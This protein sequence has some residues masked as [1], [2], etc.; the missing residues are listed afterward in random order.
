MLFNRWRLLI[1]GA[2]FGSVITAGIFI[3]PPIVASKSWPWRWAD[4]TG[5]GEDTIK[6]TSTEKKGGKNSSIEKVI[7]TDETRS[8]KTLWDFLEL[9]AVPFLLLY[10]GNQLQQKDK[11]VA[12]I[13]LR[14]EALLNY[15]D[16]VSDLLIN[17]KVNSLQPN[18]TLLEL[19]NDIIRTR[20]L[21]ILRSFGKDG[22]RKGS[23]IRFLIDAEFISNWHSIVLDLSSASLKG[24]K[25]SGTKLSR[26]K[27][28]KAD[29]SDADLSDA[30][31]SHADIRNANLIN[32]DLINA[33]LTGADLTGADLTGA[34]LTGADLT[35][36][37]LRD[38]IL[39]D[40]K[41]LRN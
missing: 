5:I 30:D 8:G 10:L 11:E 36:A 14:E 12:D 37:D 27:L 26:V 9:L 19:I 32:A 34:D 17:N 6:K 33:D 41:G 4:W 20:T 40:V 23:V 18:D 39:N 31:L 29:L 1:A 21:T 35:G 28:I 15:L 3:V 22:E 25:L 7:S 38:A 24:A 16:R 2:I 13:N